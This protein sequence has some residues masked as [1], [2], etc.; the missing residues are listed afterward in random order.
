MLIVAYLT[1]CCWFVVWFTHASC[2]TLPEKSH[3]KDGR[4]PLIISIL[5]LTSLDRHPIRRRHHT[6]KIAYT[7]PAGCKMLASTRPMPFHSSCASN[8][9]ASLLQFMTALCG[10]TF[11]IRNS[12]PGFSFCYDR[13]SIWWIFAGWPQVFVLKAV[14]EKTEIHTKSSHLGPLCFV[15]QRIMQWFCQSK[16]LTYFLLIWG[17]I[18]YCSRIFHLKKTM[19]YGEGRYFGDQ[20]SIFDANLE[21]FPKKPGTIFKFKVSEWKLKWLMLF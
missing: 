8:W 5:D 16:A 1:V 10:N 7:S 12:I 3:P 11:S 4:S 13:I 20:D 17:F 9:K 6:R 15:D 18:F 21:W 2:T 19:R 14:N